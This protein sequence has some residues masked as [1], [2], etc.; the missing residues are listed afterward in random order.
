[1]ATN[2]ITRIIWKATSIACT[3]VLGLAAMGGLIILGTVG[4]IVCGVFRFFL[5][6]ATLLLSAVVSIVLFIWFLTL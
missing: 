6:V 1:M 3:A 4:E 5:A 2:I